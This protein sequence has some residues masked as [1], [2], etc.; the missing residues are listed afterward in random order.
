MGKRI[1]RG[2]TGKVKY[3]GQRGKA[4]N[5]DKG[6]DTGKTGKADTGV[7]SSLAFWVFIS[8]VLQSDRHLDCGTVSW[9]K[10]TGGSRFDRFR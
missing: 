4:G 2:N 6:H 9:S 1:A 8:A 5:D 3:I 7:C 10:S